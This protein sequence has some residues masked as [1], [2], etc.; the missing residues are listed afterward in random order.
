MV[1]SDYISLASVL[2][3][4]IALIKSFFN[5]KK[6]KKQQLEINE[7]K[8]EVIEKKKIDEKKSNRYS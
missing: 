5:D 2:I 1:M 7:Y 6:I 3:A 8:L 4:L